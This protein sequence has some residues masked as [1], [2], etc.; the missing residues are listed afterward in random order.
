MNLTYRSDGVLTLRRATEVSES[1]CTKTAGNR[2]T[3]GWVYWGDDTLLR[4]A[5]VERFKNNCPK[6]QLVKGAER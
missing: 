3:V 2:D 6:M 4:Q 1:T 5:P